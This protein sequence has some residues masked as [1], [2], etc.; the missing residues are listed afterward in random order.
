MNNQAM[1]I[2]GLALHSG[3]ALSL[4]ARHH[5]HRCEKI[6][7]VGASAFGPLKLRHRTGAGVSDNQLSKTRRPDGLNRL[8]LPILTTSPP[9]P[10]VN[11]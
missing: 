3:C 9:I 8:A 5:R 7:G 6:G 11:A 4:A 10:F 1:F 2:A